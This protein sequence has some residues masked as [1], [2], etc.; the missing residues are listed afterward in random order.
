MKKFLL[1]F[2]LFTLHFAEAQVICV[3]CFHQNDSISSGVHNL[4]LNGSF[5]INNCTP[6]SCFC[7]N[8]SNYSCDITDWT[9]TGGGTSTYA[10]VF[11]TSAVDG[12]NSVY[13]GN[14]FCNA[15]SPTSSDTS[16]LQ[17]SLCEVGG[18]PSGYPTNTP[19][20]G[21]NTGLSLSQTV[22]GLSPG[23]CYVLEFWAGG[24]EG[25]TNRGVFGVDVGFGNMFLST[26]ETGFAPDTVGMRYVI[27]FVA[28]ATS[29]TIKF[30]NWG[31]ICSSCTELILD[32]VRVYSLQELSTSIPSCNANCQFTPPPPTPCG[33]VLPIIPNVFTPNGDGINDSLSMTFDCGGRFTVYN[34][35]GQKVFHTEGT[36]ISWDGKINGNPAT[37]GVY[38]YIAESNE[39]VYKGFVELIR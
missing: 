3:Q 19:N 14:F 31:H 9:C 16:C 29:Q 4:I 11:N 23:D 12:S 20:Y 18:I 1:F 2:S 25:F 8:S 22:N 10:T 35:W 33:T 37:D 32:N 5:E 6:G 13:F 28:N 17:D 21:G 30:T 7:P 26:H 34:R 15:C 39:K 27:E 24:E 36:R 38:Y